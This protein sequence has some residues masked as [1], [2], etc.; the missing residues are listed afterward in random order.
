MCASA[1]KSERLLC[2]G[3]LWNVRDLA[4]LNKSDSEPLDADG[5]SASKT[6]NKDSPKGTGSFRLQA[7]PCCPGV[8]SGRSDSDPRSPGSKIRAQ[9]ARSHRT[10]LSP[11]QQFGDFLS[12]PPRY[13]PG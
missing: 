2:A 1:R 4:R 5:K 7:L 12:T 9:M 11:D 3:F 6:P 8:G 10:V 13:S